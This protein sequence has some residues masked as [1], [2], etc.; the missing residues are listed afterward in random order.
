MSLEKIYPE[1]ETAGG[2]ANAINL[3]FEK[4]NSPLKVAV[5]VDYEIIPTSYARVEND[6]KFSQDYIAA[7]EKLYL[8]SFWR[9]GVCLAHGGTASI[10]DL[11]QVI[12]YWLTHNVST[13]ELSRQFDFVEPSEKA[14]AF[15]EGNEVEYTWNRLLS[16]DDSKGLNDFVELARKDEIINKLFPF[17]SLYTLCFSK[18]TGYPYDTTDMPNVT[19][20]QIAHFAIPKNTA[21]YEKIS[22]GTNAPNTKLY[23]VTKNKTEFIGEGDAVESLKL[24]R[25]SLPKDIKPARKGT[26]ED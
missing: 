9:E 14:A 7:N 23:V 2:L 13:K 26:A 15:D 17:T 11:A 1:L 18:C 20:K 21:E 6:N 4:I 22:Q 10:A 24:V 19:A 16:D 5:D 3:E 12:H 25:Q 8:P